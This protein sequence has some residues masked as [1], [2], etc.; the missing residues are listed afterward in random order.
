[1]LLLAEHLQLPA[2][3][4]AAVLGAPG[5]HRAALLHRLPLLNGLALLVKP[6]LVVPLL[7]A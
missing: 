2:Q 6:L 4:Q 3:F 7:V 1:L 5:L